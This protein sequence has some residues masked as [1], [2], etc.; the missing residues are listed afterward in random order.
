MVLQATDFPPGWKSKPHTADPKQAASQAALLR[1]VGARNSDP[2]KVAEAHSADFAYSTA[3]VS[4][5]AASYRSQ[6]AVD[7]DLA[8]VRS[9]KFSPC[10]EQTL[11]KQ[12]ATSL[13]PG[14][15]VES[16]SFKVTPGADGGPVN[17]AATGTGLVKVSL[18]GQEVVVYAKVA[19][20]V[21]PLVEA[22][23]DATSVGEPVTRSLMRS[24]VASVATRAG[25]E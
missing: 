11:A 4:S 21:G 2:D 3:T 23:V 16:V 25:K 19:F 17:V 1:C 13:P 18:S 10:H 20:I 22:E 5:S 6:K 7:A 12:I 24:L 9:P 14:A 8:M 15:K